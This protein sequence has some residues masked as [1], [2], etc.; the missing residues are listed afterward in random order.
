MKT[1]EAIEYFS[2]PKRLYELRV[3]APKSAIAKAIN[4]ERESPYKW[5]EYP[6]ELAQWRL[7]QVT[8]GKLKVEKELLLP[9]VK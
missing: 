3:R 6:P 9:A 1:Q 5:G 2:D 4:L 7:Q 8:R